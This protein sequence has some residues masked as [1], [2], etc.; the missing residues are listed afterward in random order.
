VTWSGTWVYFLILSN[1]LPTWIAETVATFLRDR[2]FRVHMGDK[3]SSWRIL[4]CPKPFQ[5]VHQRPAIN[6]LKEIYL[7]W[8]YICL[9]AQSHN[10][11]EVEEI[12]NQNLEKMATF[13]CRWRLK[14]SSSKTFWSAFH[15]HNATA[16]QKLNLPLNGQEIRLINIWEL[17]WTGPWLSIHIS[18]SLPQNLLLEIIFSACWSD[19][20]GAHRFLLLEHRRWLC[21]TL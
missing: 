18:K 8:W 20:H 21:A 5:R 10:L 13:F 17:L 12:F 15:L 6:R 3:C 2:R 9:A 4:Y 16:N 11:D 14:P 7:C 19:L 1:V